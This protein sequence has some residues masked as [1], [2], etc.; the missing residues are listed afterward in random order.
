MAIH[1]R[2]RLTEWGNG[3]GIRLT[4]GEARDLGVDAGDTIEA[5]IR[6][7]P[8][9]NDVQGLPAYRLGGTYD[10]DEVLEDEA[11]AGR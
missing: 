3:Y 4:K 9:A 2:R 10:I 6:T 1:I 7:E 8:E 11:N 5:D